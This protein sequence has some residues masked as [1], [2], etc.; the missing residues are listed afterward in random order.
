MDAFLEEYFL[1]C[2][3]KAPNITGFTFEVTGLPYI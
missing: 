2:I 3:S 1:F